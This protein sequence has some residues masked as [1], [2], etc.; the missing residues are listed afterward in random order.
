MLQT[1]LAPSHVP[2]ALLPV[3]LETRFFAVSGGMELRI[4][5]YPD[6]IHLDSHETLLTVAE[7][8]WGVHFWSQFWRAGGGAEAQA[9][10]WRQLAE[11]Y[12]AARAAWIARQLRPLNPADEPKAPIAA[13][14]PLV[15]PPSFPNPPTALPGDDAAWRR[16]PMARL[17][18]ERWIAVAYHDNQVALVA[19]GREIVLPLPA[20]PDPSPTAVVPPPSD[21]TLSIDNGMRWMVDFTEAEARGMALRMMLTPTQVAVGI[22]TL[23]VF[24]V[25]GSLAPADGAAQ[26]A[27]LLDAHHYTDGLEFLRFGAP[28]NNTTELRSA[29]RGGADASEARSFASELGAPAVAAAALP[30]SNAREFGEALG[31]LP[32]AVPEV[33]GRVPG[34]GDSADL[35]GAAMNT[36]LWPVT[37]GYYLGNLIGFDGTGLTT[38]RLALARRHFID[39]VRGSGPLAA[40][41]CGRQPYGVLP[42]TS[43]DQWLPLPTGGAAHAQLDWLRA[44]LKRLRD[45][46]WRGALAE[47]PR[48]GVPADPHEAL[49]RVMRTEAVSSRYEMRSVLGRH[50]T[51]HLRAFIGEDLAASGWIGTQDGAAAGILQRMN[52][53]WRP[54]LAR[55]AYA[56]TSHKLRAPLVQAGEV[57]ATR[58]LEPNYIAG[59]LAEKTIADIAAKH[60]QVATGGTLLH[61]LLRHALLLEYAG[62]AAAIVAT[63][64]VPLTTLLRDAELVDLVGGA[65]PTPTWQR[66]LDQRVAAVTGTRTVREHLQSDAG[67]QGAP[68]TTLR[69]MRAALARLQKC[70]SEA[71]QYLMQTTLD[72]ASHRLEAWVTSY[73]TERLATMRAAQP[74]GLIVGA[75]GWVENVQGRG[76]GQPVDPL[77]D[78]PGPLFAARGDTGFIHAPSMTQA[79]TAALLRNAHLGVDGVANP[80]APLSIDLSSRR[81][82]TAR[83]L[84]DGVRRGQP[85]GALLGYRFERRLHDDGLDAEIARFRRIA[86]L[87][88]DKLAASAL[89]AESI[90]AGNV[91]DGLRLSQWWVENRATA[92]TGMDWKLAAALDDLG[93]TIDAVAD[94]LTAEAAHQAVTG[95]VSRAA[96]TLATLTKG[97]GAVPELDVARTPRT[98]LA[99]THRVLL[100]FAGAP[101]AT[102]GWPAPAT[103]PRA[104]TEPILNAWSARVLGDARKVRCLVEVLNDAGGVAQTLELALSELQIAPLD[105]VYGVDASARSSQASALE[106]RVLYHARQKLGNDGARLRIRTTRP[107]GAAASDLFLA[108]AIGQ[109]RALKKLFAGARPLDAVDLDLPER[110]AGGTIDTTR[111]GSRVSK[112]ETTLGQL[113]DAAVAEL[114]KGD[115]ATASALRTLSLQCD[116]FGLAGAIPTSTNASDA[117]TRDV[118][119][120]QLSLLVEQMKTR[121]ANA[122][123][124]AAQRPQ[125]A[126]ALDSTEAFRRHLAQR[127]ANVFGSAFVALPSFSCGNAAELAAA[128]ADSTAVQ[129]GDP[130]AAATWFERCKRVRDPLARLGTALTG[131]EVLATGERAALRVAQLP[132]KSGA[133]WAALPATPAQ[134]LL[135][136]RVSLVIQAATTLT[137]ELMGSTTELWGLMVDEWVEMVPNEREATA[138]TFQ[139]DPPNACAPQAVLLAVPPVAGKPWT[140]EALVRVLFETLEWAKLRA[141]DAEALGELGHYLPALHVGFNAAGDAVSTDFKPLS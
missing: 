91:V 24:G 4:R 50:Y 29:Y 122:A 87:V 17:L 86:P 76:F 53:P 136:G 103:S 101:P 39:H 78:E 126:D 129:G 26:F 7:R 61:A 37:W 31:L 60:I 47:A 38:E 140:G 88:A 40:I 57:S 75:Y 134:P 58:A 33:L 111:L 123:T 121:L 5:V 74:T 133:R 110:A 95:N 43:L 139:T 100:L 16:A 120:R 116:G 83:W 104:R 113:R 108:D 80:N 63:T 1:E 132:H 14:K 82:R 54:R 44:T 28:T 23:I 66:Q 115:A 42:V 25:R 10:A 70:D 18:P 32:T 48:L 109:A 94:A 52:F 35:D 19:S 8:E 137:P 49:A 15:P 20:G 62:A 131:A 102:P 64:G 93:E 117:A 138:I 96:S 22:Q 3:R 27:A 99:V 68:A 59:L 73:A 98:G 124:M 90:A 30:G 105:V 41:R 36:A 84:L 34:A 125:P 67:L 128:L 81:M 72:L 97:E 107:A 119:R 9:R 79:A 92:S 114:A 46:I 135:P 2:V 56:D 85:L 65:A 13:D 12:G 130:L 106:Q 71:L 112:L 69:E 21:D 51:Q 127:F 11:R 55:G 141:V 45:N 6:K 89:P 118:L 77:P